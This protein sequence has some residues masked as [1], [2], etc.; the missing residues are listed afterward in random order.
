VQPKA[1]A[2]EFE[3]RLRTAL[4]APN[5]T[6]REVP[7]F[8]AYADEFKKT[9]VLANNKPSERSMKASIR[10]H[11]LL[12]GFGQ[13]QLSGYGTERLR[14]RLACKKSYLTQV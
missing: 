13:M 3:H 8:A 14:P 12:P 4:L 7:T 11:H 1:G 5:L 6:T 9:Y 2:D 10:K